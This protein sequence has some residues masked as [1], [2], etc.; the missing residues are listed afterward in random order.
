MV[1]PRY[2]PEDRWLSEAFA[3]FMA[4]EYYKVRYEGEEKLKR[5]IYEDWAQIHVEPFKVT[6]KNIAGEKVGTDPMEG[7]PLINGSQNV[8]SKGPA[9][10]HM[11]RYTFLVQKGDD[12]AFWGML[13]DFLRRFHY[14]RASTSDFI[15]VAEEHLGVSLSWFWDQWLYGRVVPE[16]SWSKRLER[17]DKGWLLTVQASQTTDFTLVIPIYVHFGSGKFISR[18]LLLEGAEGQRQL[19]LPEEP[20]QVTLN[21]FYESLVRLKP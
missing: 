19:L 5:R 2:W 9:V 21:D 10:L 7:T 6:T 4:L 8:Y 17:N 18:P 1:E 3:D 13:Q 16:V 12:E 14:K 11:L 20:K 15:K